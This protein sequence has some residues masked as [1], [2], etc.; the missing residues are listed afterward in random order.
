MEKKIKEFIDALQALL[1]PCS[2][3]RTNDIV[4]Y[5]FR[6]KVVKDGKWVGVSINLHY[7][8]DVGFEVYAYQTKL[9][10]E[11]AMKTLENNKESK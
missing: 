2:V 10:I 3:T 1:A 5:G 7:L 6:I 11:E 9:L 4:P 8:V